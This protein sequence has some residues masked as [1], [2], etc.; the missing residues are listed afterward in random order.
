MG[1]APWLR[2]YGQDPMSGVLFF[3]RSL[4]SS[5]PIQP[6]ALPRSGQAQ[7]AP[8][9]EREADGDLGG[10]R[11]S[12]VASGEAPVAA[13]RRRASTL[14][15]RA[16]ARHWAPWRASQLAPKL[17]AELDL[18]P[19]REVAALLQPPHRRRNGNIER[20]LSQPDA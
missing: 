4:E 8:D 7:P 9:H 17:L 5:S 16:N 12:A 18:L 1:R 3:S 13:A 15:L 10:P 14:P 6:L 20:C 2:P 11:G 19:R